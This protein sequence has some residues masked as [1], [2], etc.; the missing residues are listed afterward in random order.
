M[1]TEIDTGVAAPESN[2]VGIMIDGYETFIGDDYGLLEGEMSMLDNMQ[3]MIYECYNTIGRHFMKFVPRFY[4]GKELI[5]ESIITFEMEYSEIFGVLSKKRVDEI[6]EKMMLA[7]IPYGLKVE[8]KKK[9]AD[10]APDE[11]K[12]TKWLENV[13]D[14]TKI[15]RECHK[16]LPVLQS[17]IVVNPMMV[18]ALKQTHEKISCK[19]GRFFIPK[20]NDEVLLVYSFARY[21]H[22][23]LHMYS[24]P[25]KMLYYYDKGVYKYDDANLRIGN[26]ITETLKN[27]YRTKHMTNLVDGLHYMYQIDRDSLYDKVDILNCLNGYYDLVT[28]EFKPHTP[29]I[30]TGFQFNVYYDPEAK[31]PNITK[32]FMDVL[33]DEKWRN[34]VL[35][36]LAYCL[37]P[38][39]D[40]EKALF[41]L[42][43]GGNGK[44]KLISMFQKFVGDAYSNIPIQSLEGNRFASSSIEGKLINTF[45]DLPNEYMQDT[46]VFKGIVGRDTIMGEKKFKDIYSFT[47]RCRF[48]VSMNQ[49]P[50]VPE[51]D[52]D[53]YFRRIILVHFTQNF[54]KNGKDDPQILEK[55]TLPEELS[56]LFNML[57]ER[58]IKLRAN[59]YKIEN[60]PSTEDTRNNYT[61]HSFGVRA[62]CN[63]NIRRNRNM[64]VSVEFLYG[65]YCRWCELN[66]IAPVKQLQFTKQMKKL[67]FIP[68][69]VYDHRT[70][71]SVYGYSGIITKSMIDARRGGEIDPSI[72]HKEVERQQYLAVYSRKINEQKAVKLSFYN[73]APENTKIPMYAAH[74]IESYIE[75]NAEAF[76]EHI[77]EICKTTL[78][79]KPNPKAINEL[80][81]SEDVAK[82]VM[83]NE[84]HRYNHK[85]TVDNE[86]EDFYKKKV[87]V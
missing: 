78:F 53:G 81:T 21:A 58:L 42:G 61:M 49:C 3:F 73:K 24:T 15:R 46:S 75:R 29:D 52:D 55:I 82:I 64:V 6:C 71:T 51:Q 10:A 84:C 9:N 65:D 72:D 48:L 38:V 54:K 4:C 77:I 87:G 79:E 12:E 66:G 69:T 22:E 43:P 2:P 14:A 8:R 20:E 23:H 86:V 1:S 30:M 63:E 35:D 17:S 7:S 33:P 13:T 28:N 31:C 41:M 67:E 25:N 37:V 39:M 62:Y 26:L 57:L 68:G 5:A 56:G 60:L 16:I 11:P 36:Y 80:N 34:I 18:N 74:L 27:D 83:W 85:A 44:S 59:G 47:P 50:P 76:E 19:S 70:K 32:F 40:L 45:A